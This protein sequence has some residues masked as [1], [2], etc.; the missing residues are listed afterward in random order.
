M[1][2]IKCWQAAAIGLACFSLG[3]GRVEAAPISQL[4]VFGDSNVDIGRLAA[5]LDGDPQ[6]GAVVPPNTVDGR[7][8]DGP[9]LPEFVAGRVGVPQLNFGWGGATAG[10]TN[11]VGLLF[12]DADDTLLTGTSA[13]I[14]EFEAM[15]GGAPADSDGLY[16]VFAGSN[17]LFFA[18]K[19]DQS[20]VDA[21]VGSADNNL[22]DAVTRLDGLG[23][24]RIVVSTR[25]A[26]PVLSDADT[27]SQETDP[28]ARNDASGRQLNAVIKALGTD[29]DTS[30]TADVLLFDSYGLIRDIIA[31]SGT[32]GFQSYSDAPSQ[33]C[34]NNTDCSDLINYD[35]AHKTSAV[36][37]VLA[38]EFIA[39]FNLSAKPMP[40][41]L[42]AASW[43]LLGAFGALGFAVRKR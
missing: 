5:E 23:A 8:A 27:P 32:N 1:R 9:I 43:L 22:R 21:A 29:R 39:Q 6:D 10:D 41:P 12:P 24:E 26:R 37:S 2:L 16:L 4:I 14:D 31:N 11:I 20:A 34:I 13:Q 19:N 18:D 38:D 3:A 30:L 35:A 42:P 28:A 15:L 17:D 7:S 25:T 33:Y 36:H 40:I